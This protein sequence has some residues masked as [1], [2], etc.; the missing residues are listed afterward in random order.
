MIAI[1]DFAGGEWPKLAREAAVRFCGDPIEEPK[2]V[3]L[4][5]DIKAIFDGDPENDSDD[6]CERISS[7]DLVNT[8][9]AKEGRPWGDYNQGKGITKNQVARMLKAFEIRTPKR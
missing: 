6:G 2:A 7:E 3:E 4:L 9:N 8:L 5:K 1:A